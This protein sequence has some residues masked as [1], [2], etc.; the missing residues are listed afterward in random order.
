MRE[1]TALGAA[2]AAGLAVGVWESIQDF[3]ATQVTTFHPHTSP[4]NRLARLEQWQK[5]IQKSLG[6]ISK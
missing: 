6:W 4:M 5:A 3:K 2:L 1:T